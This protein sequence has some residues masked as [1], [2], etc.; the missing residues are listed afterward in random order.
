MKTLLAAILVTLCAVTA[1]GQTIKSLGY[2]TTNGQVVY[3]GTNTLTFTNTNVE[4]LSA[5]FGNQIQ[6]A[7][8]TAGTPAFRFSTNAVGMYYGSALGVGPFLGV[9]VNS[10]AIARFATNKVFFDQ[11]I[12]FPNATNAALTRTNLG[13][14]AAWLTNT[15][16]TNFRTAIGLG[17]TNE[18][19]FGTVL[20]GRV[21]STT[22]YVEVGSNGIEF[23]EPS[24]AATTRTNL[25]L[26]WTGLTNTD[27]AAFQGALFSATTTNTPTNT[28]A[29][30]PDA[31]VDIMVGTNTYKLPLWQ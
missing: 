20:S 4:F 9:T 8:G 18:V 1:H 16:V 3:G 12:E 19:L 28:N 15:D 23:E 13:L 5:S 22:F 10:N 25:S 17:A 27:A 30:T 14:G 31:W 29:P 6:V 7:P 26:P 2:N 11:P 21:E 24:V